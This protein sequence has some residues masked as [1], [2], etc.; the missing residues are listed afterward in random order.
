MIA[1]VQ[2]VT[3][4]RVRVAERIVG[5]IGAGMAVLAAVHKTDTPDDIL[6]TAQKLV[7]LRI[8][9]NADRHFDWTCGKS[10]ARSCRSATS[11]SPPP[12]ARAV[13]RPSTPPPT[14]RPAASSSTTSSPR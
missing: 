13:A 8:F 1:V 10:T 9:R 4:A 14:P 7:A 2:G 11:P 5:E 12:P 6:W 3:E